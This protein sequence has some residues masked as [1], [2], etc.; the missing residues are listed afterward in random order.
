MTN[1]SKHSLGLF[2]P[3][4]PSWLSFNKLKAAGL[5]W[6]CGGFDCLSQWRGQLTSRNPL[7]ACA[8]QIFHPG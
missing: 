6:I 1:E 4:T 3:N 2:R 5:I 8:Y 7:N